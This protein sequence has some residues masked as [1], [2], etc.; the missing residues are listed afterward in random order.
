MTRLI[1]AVQP[2]LLGGV[3]IW[4][5][6]VKLFGRNAADGARHTA[7]APLLGTAWALPAYRLVGGVELTIGT[8][9]VLPPAL[10]V[11]AIAGTGLAAGFLAYLLY[12]RRL[13]P[14]SSCGCLSSLRTAPVSWR[15]FARG[16][17]LLV[18]GLLATRATDYWLGEILTRPFA[19]V[20]VLVEA[21]AVVMLSPELD[22]IW[23]VSLR[24]LRE[25]LP[26]PFFGGSGVALHSS[27]R[28][29]RQ[30]AAFRRVEGLLH[31]DV[32]EHWD[33]EEWR[34]VCYG[35]RYQGRP[36]TAAFAVPLLR[37]DPSAVRVALVDEFAG[38][39]LLTVV[40]VP[41]AGAVPG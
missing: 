33:E 28:Q 39:I 1:A 27:A 30:S 22:R 2:V 36:A 5:A 19:R 38:V 40:G 21:V 13:A 26:R 34:I 14:E 37:Y 16:G 29:L 11:K 6:G 4:A 41:Q 18:T 32:Q 20:A 15:S 7:L 23:L 8:L 12:A 17:L 25:R 10:T 9:L 31:P 24:H 3:L 35:A